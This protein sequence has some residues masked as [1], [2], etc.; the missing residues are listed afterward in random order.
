MGTA[1]AM[2]SRGLPGV[3]ARKNEALKDAAATEQILKEKEVCALVQ[4]LSD[5]ELACLLDVPA[6]RAEFYRYLDHI[7]CGK[8]HSKV[9]AAMGY[10]LSLDAR[11]KNTVRAVEQLAR[12]HY[13]WKYRMAP[14]LLSN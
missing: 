7:S 14:S 6:Y 1:T 9:V 5:L 10:C 11:Q 2:V 13:R 3:I 12:L 8:F 4:G